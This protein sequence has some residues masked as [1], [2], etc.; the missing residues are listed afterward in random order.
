MKQILLFLALFINLI[1]YTQTQIG[2]DI[3][4]EAA[5]DFFGTGCSV[6][7]DGSVIAIGAFGNDDNGENSGHVRIYENINKVYG[8]R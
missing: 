7:S 4:G 8:H 6:S 3:D 2:Q 5:G 1:V